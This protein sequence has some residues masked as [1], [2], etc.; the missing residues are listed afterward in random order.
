MANAMDFSETQIPDDAGAARQPARARRPFDPDATAPAPLRDA[1]PPDRP[2]SL[3]AGTFPAGPPPE[4]EDEE[5]GSYLEELGVG[6]WNVAWAVLNLLITL[7]IG[8]GAS[9]M[10]IGDEWRFLAE[11]AWKVLPL[12]G[13]VLVLITIW[14]KSSAYTRNSPG[15]SRWTLLLSLA[16][17]LLWLAL[18][19]G[20]SRGVS[21]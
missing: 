12:S 1:P 4:Y 16:A 19:S 11:L 2:T 15:K 14:Q 6:R 9:L 18:G 10:G 13:G 17:L 3:Q 7:W 20:I 5:P 21:D 8:A